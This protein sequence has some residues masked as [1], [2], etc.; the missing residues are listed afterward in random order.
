MEDT[1]LTR[2]LPEEDERNMAIVR[3]GQVVF[4]S[5]ERGIAP[6]FQAARTKGNSLHNAGRDDR[7]MCLAAG[8]CPFQ[9]LAGG[10]RKPSELLAALQSL[11]G[12]G[13]H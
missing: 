7:I 10:C 3:E 11:F 4:G 2:W 9:M 12:E 6:F 13:D 8:L 1:E 5:R